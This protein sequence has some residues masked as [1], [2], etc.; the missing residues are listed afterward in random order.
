MYS[1]SF[2]LNLK[3]KMFSVMSW[4]NKSLI[5]ANTYTH[6]YIQQMREDQSAIYYTNWNY[7]MEWQ[8]SVKFSTEFYVCYSKRCDTYTRRYCDTCVR[9]NELLLYSLVPGRTHSQFHLIALLIVILF[10]LQARRK[11]SNI[12]QC[13]IF[14]GEFCSIRFHSNLCTY[15]YTKWLKYVVH[16]LK[17]GILSV[18]SL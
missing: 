9:G 10:S 2:N 13:A 7:F 18:S 16:N 14:G 1:S 11:I 6:T 17:P 12:F 15:M 4:K 5:Q 8:N 3:C